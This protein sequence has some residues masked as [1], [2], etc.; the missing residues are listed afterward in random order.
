MEIYLTYDW[1]GKRV[2]Q[3][4][5]LKIFAVSVLPCFLLG[6]FTISIAL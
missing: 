3:N 1:D 2:Q 4:R 6:A 5:R